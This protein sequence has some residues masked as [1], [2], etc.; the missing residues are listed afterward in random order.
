MW[1]DSRIE[2]R[3]TSIP[4]NGNWYTG[5][6]ADLNLGNTSHLKMLNGVIDVLDFRGDSTG[7]ISGGSINYIRSIQLSGTTKHITF[8]CDVDSVN[9][10]GNLLTGDWLD[11]KG[12]FSITLL[13]Q[14]P[15]DSVYSNIEF[16]PEPATLALLA[17]GGLLLRHKR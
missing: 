12:D 10:T 9:L 3:Y 16:I 15:Y 5:G 2:V 4:V 13:D 14:S 8:I 6:I 1:N 7:E 11:G 17:L